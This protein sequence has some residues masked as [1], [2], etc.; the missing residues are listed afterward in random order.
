[1]KVYVIVMLSLAIIRALS[2]LV[3]DLESKKGPRMLAGLIFLGSEIL[4]LIFAVKIFY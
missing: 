3:K 2:G 4:A 1:M